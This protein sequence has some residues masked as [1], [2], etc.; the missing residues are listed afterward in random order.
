MSEKEALLILNATPNLSNKRLLQLLEHFGSAT[1]IL[2][3]TRNQL[4]AT[5]FLTENAVL[6]VLAFDRAKFIEEENVLI[7][8][9]GV[10]IITIFDQQYPQ[11]LKEIVDAPVVLYVKGELPHKFE[12]GYSI[13]GSRRA[14]LYGQS[15]AEKFAYQLALCHLP[16][17]SGLAAGIDAAAHRGALKAHG[18]T[19]GVLGCG[20]SQVYPRENAY[21]YEKIAQTGAIISEFPMCMPPVS[22]NF[23]RRNRIVSGLSKGVIVV[24][25]AKR[26]GALIT[27]DFALEQGREVFAVPGKIDNP[28]SIGVNGLIKQG[29]Q[30]VTAIE[31]V[32]KNAQDLMK[33]ELKAINKDDR[34]HNQNISKSLTDD[35]KTVYNQITENPV[36]IDKVLATCA[37]NNVRYAPAILLKLELKHLI[38]QLPGKLYRK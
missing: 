19:V 20:L 5:G 33:Q 21:L 8:K 32:I 11:Q 12:F 10:D 23:P 1:C 18:V 7:A 29:A 22:Y 15:V 13:V 28:V 34:D 3:Q 2:Q 38:T 37:E 36:H 17:I 31:D 14:S 26:S 35:E 4:Q 30:I 24:E 9:Y 6:K 27:V 25:A 16:V